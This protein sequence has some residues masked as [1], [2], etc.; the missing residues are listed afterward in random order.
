MDIS[1]NTPDVPRADNPS[2]AEEDTRG[3]LGVLAGRA[4][5]PEVLMLSSYSEDAVEP[6]ESLGFCKRDIV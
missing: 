3:R 2:A 6:R 1:G 4:S 5:L